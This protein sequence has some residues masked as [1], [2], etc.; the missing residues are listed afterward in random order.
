MLAAE[1]RA[2]REWLDRIE[3]LKKHPLTGKRHPVRQQYYKMLDV[4]NDQ[5]CDQQNVE[6]AAVQPVNDE[7][8]DN[9]EQPVTELKCTSLH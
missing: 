5:K 1:E 6:M 9:V 2:D 3:Y 4:F 8:E 7:E